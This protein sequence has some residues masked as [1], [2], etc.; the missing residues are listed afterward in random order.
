M[1]FWKHTGKKWIVH[2]YAVYETARDGDKSVLAIVKDHR[3]YEIDIN[4]YNVLRLTL[5]SALKRIYSV[6]CLYE[7]NINA[8]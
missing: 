5:N 2:D 3:K 7:F 6:D 1:S 8:L 4:Y